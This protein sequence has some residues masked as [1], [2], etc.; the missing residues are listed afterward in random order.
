[1]ADSELR[2][3]KAAADKP[4]KTK[5]Q[6]PSDDDGTSYTPWVDILRVIT[7]VIVASC[8]LSYMITSGKSFV[9]GGVARPDVLRLNWWQEKLVR[10]P[11]SPQSHDAQQLTRPAARPRLHDPRRALSLLRHRP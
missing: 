7:F 6:D 3:R 11:S 4:S 9:W 8:G 2:Q 1:M 10:S 5:K